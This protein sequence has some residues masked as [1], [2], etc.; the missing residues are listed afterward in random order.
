M[1]GGKAVPTSGHPMSSVTDVVP[2]G[3]IQG[4]GYGGVVVVIECLML[5]RA[6]G[7]SILVGFI[8]FMI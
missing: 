3:Y 5:L 7:G 6:L 8:F 1:V 2:A 4:Y